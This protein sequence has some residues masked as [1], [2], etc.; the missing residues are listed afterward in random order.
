MVVQRE[1]L[2]LVAGERGRPPLEG[3]QDSVRLVL[4]A[5]RGRA[6]LHGLHRV[7]D[8]VE[9]ALRRPGRHVRV[10]LVTELRGRNF[11]LRLSSSSS[12]VC[13][14]VSLTILMDS[15]VD[16]EDNQLPMAAL[17]ISFTSSRILLCLVFGES[18]A[19]AACCDQ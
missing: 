8:L 15:A 11:V 5:D 4:E 9:A 18:F 7:L 2:L 14:Q 16:L 17:M 1:D 13:L 19:G 10:V 3:R 12:T 6:L